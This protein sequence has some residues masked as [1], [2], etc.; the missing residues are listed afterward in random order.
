MLLRR[1]LTRT[2]SARSVPFTGDLEASGKLGV[3]GVT[4]MPSDEWIRTFADG[5]SVKFS[6]DELIDATFIT[7]QIE[8]NEVVYSILLNKAETNLSRKEVEG[9]FQHELSKK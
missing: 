6:H 1:W 7:A 2:G 3:C 9:R 5:R 8:G 4:K